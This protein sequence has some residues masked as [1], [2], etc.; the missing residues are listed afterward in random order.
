MYLFI[1]VCMQTWVVAFLWRS[2]DNLPESVFSFHFMS[3]AWWQVLLPLCSLARPL[4]VVLNFSLPQ[5]FKY[6]QNLTNFPASPSSTLMP[7]TVPLSPFAGMLA[8]TVP[9]VCFHTTIK[10]IGSEAKQFPSFLLN[11]PRA[12]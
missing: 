12:F 10:A 6:I 2:E 8:F 7:T 11:T 4:R 1:C 3:Q 9:P 5:S